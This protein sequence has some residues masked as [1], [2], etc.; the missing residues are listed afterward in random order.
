MWFNF[1]NPICSPLFFLNHALS[2][3]GLSVDDGS[4]LDWKRHLNLRDG[5]VPAG[6]EE[7]DVTFGRSPW[8]VPGK[9]LPTRL[10]N[11]RTE[12]RKTCQIRA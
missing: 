4:R 2:G 7:V 10:A 8:A 1:L 12:A 11:A 6:R 3:Q 9:C 5:P